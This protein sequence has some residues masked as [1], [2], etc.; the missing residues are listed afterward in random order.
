MKTD[1]NFKGIELSIELVDHVYKRLQ[2]VEALLKED[3]RNRFIKA[4]FTIDKTSADYTVKFDLK[5]HKHT[6]L[7]SR[8]GIDIKEEL[9]YVIDVMY[10]LLEKAEAESK[11]KVS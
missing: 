11:R 1:I 9:D 6:L 8:H 10:Q 3:P 2:A 7:M 5:T 4:E